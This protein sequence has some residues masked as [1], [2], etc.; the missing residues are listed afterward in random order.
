VTHTPK[1]HN[2]SRADVDKLN[3]IL[4][5]IGGE[6]TAVLMRGWRVGPPARRG[7]RRGMAIV[8][9]DLVADLQ[10]QVSKLGPRCDW[11]ASRRARHARIKA[12]A[13]AARDG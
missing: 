9:Q 2:L 5:R 7:W 11:R 10:A 13:S 12:S 6:L 4:G 3:G 1:K 8:T